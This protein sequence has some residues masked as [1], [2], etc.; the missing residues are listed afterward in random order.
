MRCFLLQLAYPFVF[1]V[2]VMCCVL[3][4]AYDHLNGLSIWKCKCKD[5]SSWWGVNCVRH[6]KT[7]DHVRY[8]F[9]IDS[10][11]R[12][13]GCY[14]CYI[15]IVLS[16]WLCLFIVMTLFFPLW[17]W[18]YNL[19]IRLFPRFS[20]YLSRIP[21]LYGRYDESNHTYRLWYKMIYYLCYWQRQK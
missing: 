3:L 21:K 8:N 14:I 7:L 11:L 20:M 16:L 2:S 18:I 5:T 10:K 1:V 19:C 4:L 13:L 6:G 15:I 12:E 9:R 17:G